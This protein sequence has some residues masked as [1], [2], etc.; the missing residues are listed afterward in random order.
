MV[1]FLE[2]IKVLAAMAGY[3]ITIITLVGLICRPIR[4]NIIKK[5]SQDN[6]NKEVLDAIKELNNEVKELKISINKL[7]DQQKDDCEATR[8]ALRNTITHL[9]YKYTKI[10]EIPALE[11]ENVSMLCRAYFALKGNSYVQ[12]CYEE[13]MDLPTMC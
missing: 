9:Y 3:I 12:G 6:Q 5:F 1:D 2:A 8:C 10:G 7:E 11:R 4:E 13:L